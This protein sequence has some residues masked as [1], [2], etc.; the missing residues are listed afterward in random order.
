MLEAGATSPTPARSSSPPL[1]GAE[2]RRRLTSPAAAWVASRLLCLAMF[3][4]FERTVHFD[5]H[6]YWSSVD[7]L[8]DGAPLGRTMRE[9]PVPVLLTMVPQYVVALGNLNAMYV[10][11]VASML[12]LD[13]MFA[14]ALLRA[15]GRRWSPGFVFWLAFVPMV[16][17]L[18]YFRFDLVPAVLVGL[19]LLR[20]RPSARTGVLIAT[21][22]ALKFWPALLLPV[23]LI[24]GRSR[25]AVIRGFT[26]AGGLFAA[27]SLAL[28]GPGRLLSPLHW[29]SGRG[30]Q[31]ESIWATP[32]M[33]AH[34]VDQDP[35]RIF[36]S[37]Y[38]AFEIHGF[39]SHAVVV[40]ASIAQLAGLVVLAG[41]LF[42]VY[43][44]QAM[45][46]MSELA[47]WLSMST[48]GLVILTDKTLSPQYLLWLG[49]PL[50][51]ILVR[52]Q[53][54]DAARRIAATVLAAALTSQAV[55]PLFYG[56]IDGESAAER[57]Y[58][59]GLLAL[60]NVLLVAAIVASVIA[61]WR[62]A[63][64]RSADPA[65]EPV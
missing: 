7:A 59:V 52:S 23:F 46:P 6:Y 44:C 9:Y 10:V 47:G 31:V 35:W 3:A 8:R 29:Q 1:F 26:V 62:A 12:A 56:G 63:T 39:G 18:T 45:Q 24:D 41:L 28:G 25:A 48:V 5:V 54:G 16:G 64:C 33:V 32:L 42:R 2:L 17:P 22:A 61:T 49:G 43:R 14:H 65:Q 34:A 53:P 11:F 55:Y 15:R 13:A 36:N 19:A 37:R 60:R 27:G 58:S 40:A 21:G 30:L 57:P 51:V 50:A 38:Q 4:K 20:P